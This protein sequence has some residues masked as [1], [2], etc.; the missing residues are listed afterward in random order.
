MRAKNAG[1]TPFSTRNH[2]ERFDLGQHLKIF[3]L[4]SSEKS[5]LRARNIFLLLSRGHP[6]DCHS[7]AAR[8][9]CH[10]LHEE[11]IAAPVDLPARRAP[12][13]SAGT[14]KIFPRARRNTAQDESVSSITSCNPGIL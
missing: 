6:L 12:V 2:G 11:E 7:S 10:F 9:F 1:M 4:S 5:A 3:F 14:R 13:A 8:P